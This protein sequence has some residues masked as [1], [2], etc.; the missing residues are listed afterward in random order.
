M[1]VK[2]LLELQDKDTAQIQFLLKNLMELPRKDAAENAKILE[3]YRK[4]YNW[5]V[6]RELFL[7]LWFTLAE[8]YARND[9][10]P[11]ALEYF[12]DLIEDCE[13]HQEPEKLRRAKANLATAY[14]QCGFY[15]QALDTWKVMLEED[16]PPVMQL[17]LLNNM[18]VA[19]GV[20]SNPEEGIGYGY[21][22]VALAEELNLP[23]ERIDPLIN[24][25][26]HYYHQ[27]KTERALEVWKEAL[28][29]AETYGK[30]RRCAEVLNSISLAYAKL[31]DKA[32]A[33]S[34]AHVA[35]AKALE[36]TSD[37]DIGMA[38]NNLGVINRE[39]GNST[40]A[41]A[42][43]YQARDIYE[44]SYDSVALANVLMNIAELQIAVGELDSAWENLLRSEA[45]IEEHGFS[46]I[47]ER[48]L[49]LCVQYRIKTGELD[50]ALEYSKELAE[51]LGEMLHQNS[52]N[53]IS[54]E[55]AD[56]Y[57][58]KIENQA[59]KLRKQNE[60][61]SAANASLVE[62]NDLLSRV[63]SIISHDVRAPLANIIQTLDLVNQ[64]LLNSE[65]IHTIFQDL[66]G[67][68][69]RIFDML[70]G[71]LTWL[72]TARRDSEFGESKISFDLVIL[73]EEISELYRPIAMN[74]GIILKNLSRGTELNV[75]SD[76]DLLAI[77]IRNLVNNSVKYTGKGGKIE[78]ETSREPGCFKII[79]TD[80]GTGMSRDQAEKL[81][82]GQLTGMLGTEQEPGF[83]LGFKLCLDSVKRL[84]GKIF[85]ESEL[86][87][88][89]KI[90]AKIPDPAT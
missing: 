27:D 44:N 30:L 23:K 46:V 18:S 32:N 5:E 24:I 55:E 69:S 31:G 13:A 35:L 19:S 76:R 56:Y 57:R 43:F 1:E 89:T 20:L 86:K 38:Y 53:S 29:L 33:L 82:A 58:R 83:G 34:Y 90:T 11:L 39:F 75:W 78:L 74:K 79:V 45:V 63:I 61:L 37:Q 77:M 17:T 73:L 26:S 4:N 50:K 51:F 87:Q 52:Q 66:Q 3:V 68:S 28:S 85:I 25:G 62:T 21:R 49:K 40:E 10:I 71:V 65:T 12:E 81:M 9:Q 36:Y 2:G 59:E 72:N 6:N 48:Y 41:L 47:R 84:G 15:Q 70:N 14:A 22:A 8:Y 88:G 67:S 42:F 7:E 54:T 80:T 64:G 16:L 60:E